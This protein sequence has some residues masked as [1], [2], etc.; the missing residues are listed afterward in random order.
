MERINSNL[1]QGVLAV[2]CLFFFACHMKKATKVSIT[3][4][5]EKP[6][7][8]TVKANNI[9]LRLDGVKPGERR[10]GQMDWTDIEKKDGQWILF[11]RNAETGQTDSF[12]HGMFRNGE[13]SNFLDAEC[14]ESQLKINVSE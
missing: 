4:H 12:A 11:V 2:L 9:V 10:E 6:I 7:D 3:N 1:Q 14:S 5:Y 13:L 8:F